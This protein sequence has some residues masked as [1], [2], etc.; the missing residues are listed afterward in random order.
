MSASKINYK[1]CKSFT[2]DVTYIHIPKKRDKCNIIVLMVDKICSRY[3]AVKVHP[4]SC[5]CPRIL[6]ESPYNR[7]F[8][9][10]Y[11]QVPAKPAHRRHPTPL[12][13]YVL[14][15]VIVQR[16]NGGTRDGATVSS[17]EV[18][19]RLQPTYNDLFMV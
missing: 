7:V 1:S 4:S 10:P 18:K 9:P 17:D 8:R 13:H 14:E 2:T 11:L 12:G 3:E 16:V 6:V 5:T 19:Q 15:R